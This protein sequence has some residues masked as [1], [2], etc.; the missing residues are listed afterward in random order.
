MT[1]LIFHSE[2]YNI[3]LQSCQAFFLRFGH[4][5]GQEASIIG[6]LDL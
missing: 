3:I 1:E 2:K 5:F 4:E 6:R